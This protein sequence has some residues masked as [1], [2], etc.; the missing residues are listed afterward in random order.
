LLGEEIGGPLVGL[1][2]CRDVTPGYVADSVR[3][4]FTGYESDAE[5]GLNFAQARYQSPVQGRFTSVEPLGA[6][7]NV[8]NPQSFNRYS[9][10]NNNPVNSVDPTGMSLQDIGIVQTED[11][12]Y[13][14][15]LQGASDAQFQHSVNLDVQNRQLEPSTRANSLI[16][17][18][19]HSARTGVDGGS[20]QNTQEAITNNATPDQADLL[21]SVAAEV[22]GRMQAGPCQEFFGTRGVAAI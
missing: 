14:R 12:S 18:M 11:E 7:T 15:T 19:A 17:E 13:A 5:T 16:H 9:Y 10:V 1:I 3:Q 6:S 2:G 22:V 21:I 20:P 4:K 8:G